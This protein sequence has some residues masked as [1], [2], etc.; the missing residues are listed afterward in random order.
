[1][2]DFGAENSGGVHVIVQR[3]VTYDHDAVSD[4]EKSVPDVKK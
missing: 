1:M 4:S 2:F 3:E